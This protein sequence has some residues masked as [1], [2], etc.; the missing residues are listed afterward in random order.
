MILNMNPH[1]HKLKS[2][3]SKLKS[4]SNQPQQIQINFNQTQINLHNS[5]FFSP[6]PIS[7]KPIDNKL[8]KPGTCVPFF[9]PSDLKYGI[10]FK[11]RW[12]HDR[13]TPLL[14]ERERERERESLFTIL[15]HCSLISCVHSSNMYQIHFYYFYIIF[16]CFIFS[17]YSPTKKGIY[18]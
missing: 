16:F 8:I 3:S 11:I 15:H 7:T 1:L 5:R 14:R 9:E 12:V 18:K 10:M 4:N 2:K 6:T 17:Y 13:T